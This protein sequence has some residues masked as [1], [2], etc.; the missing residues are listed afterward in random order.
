MTSPQRVLICGSRVWTDRVAIE[1]VVAQMPLGSVVIVGGATGA[2]T[3]AE[4]AARAAGLQC[5]VYPA[6][7]GLYGRR[8]GPIRNR[9]M[10]REGRPDVVVAFHAD[11]WGSRGTADM[12]RVAQAAGLPVWLVRDRDG[13]VEGT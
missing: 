4:V 3:L 11:L 10:L 13:C 12:V 7:W 2:D 1:A 9:A 5:E 8:A 6:D